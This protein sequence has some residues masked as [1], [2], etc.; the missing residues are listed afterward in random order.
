[1]RQVLQ[2]LDSGLTEIAEVPVPVCEP[3]RL[4]IQSRVSLVSLGTERML[5][6]FGKASLLGKALQRPERVKEALRKI[7]ADGLLPTVQAIRAKLSNPLPLGYSNAGIVKQV[8][9]GVSGFQVGDSVVSNGPHAEVVSVPQNLCA[10]IPT[11]ARDVSFEEAAFTVP[12]AIGMQGLRLAAPTLGEVFVVMGLG[13]I[14]Q[15]T[16]QLLQ[17]NGCTVLGIDPDGQK[18]ALARTF[19]ATVADPEAGED[20]IEFA[21]SV[22][23]GHGVDGVIITAATSSS[24]PVHQAAQMCRKRGRIILVGVTG[25]ELNRSDFYEKE[26]TFQVSCSY[27]PG[28]YDPQ[29]EEKSHDYPRGFVRWTVARNF[30]AVLGLMAQGNLDVSTLITH[31]FPI[32]EAV[33]AYE[34]VVEDRSALGVLLQYPVPEGDASREERKVRVAATTARAAVGEPVVGL[35]GAGGF[36]SRILAPAIEKAGAT[37]RT[38]VS[39]GGVS[40]WTVAKRLGCEYV[41]TEAEEVLDDDRIDT[42]FIATRHDSHARLVLEALRR[43]KHVFVE[44]PL[45]IRQEHLEEIETLYREFRA[46]SGAPVLGIGFNRRFAPHAVKMKELLTGVRSAKTMVMTVNAGAIPGDHWVHDPEIGGGRILG[47]GCHFVDLLRFL[48]GASITQVQAMTVDPESLEI[49]E[50]KMTT[51]LGFADGSLGTV[52]YFANGSKAY[53]KETLT[54]FSDGR[55]LR[56][57]NFRKLVG[58]GWSGFRK[59]SSWSQDKGHEAGVRAFLD[60]VRTGGAPPIPVEEIFEVTRTM[61]EIQ[62]RARR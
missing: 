53:P 59:M 41:A 58:Y 7:Q 48:V 54:T 16:V 19:G 31:R 23:R 50:D 21:E 60:A 26:L 38:V 33:E 62:R 57:S 35:I 14:G 51:T 56:N 49:S 1:M 10:R 17:A 18:S 6:D 12:A 2:H 34:T 9:A 22:T 28:R 25:L 13:L 15:L 30:D 32:G 47:E 8:G 46:D 5:I 24:L 29:Y 55:I 36:S 20:P 3:G 43:G 45:A 52:H 42:V 39:K 27:G 37:I 44:K 11:T 61:F 4:V 40:A